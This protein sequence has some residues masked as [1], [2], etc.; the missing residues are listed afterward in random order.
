MLE[1]LHSSF[2]LTHHIC[3]DIPDEELLNNNPQDVYYTQNTGLDVTLSE[4]KQK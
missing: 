1:N 2:S 4:I 3:D